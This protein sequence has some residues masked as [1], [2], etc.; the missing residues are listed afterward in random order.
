MD[1]THVGNVNIDWSSKV[2]AI[3]LDPVRRIS[4]P[5]LFNLRLGTGI[6]WNPHGAIGEDPLNPVT[7]LD[8]AGRTKH[9]WS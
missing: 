3:A 2:V 5:K 4:G 1:K 6:K 8:F 9:K 7:S